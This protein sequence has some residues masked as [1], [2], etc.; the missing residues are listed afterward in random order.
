MRFCSLGLFG[1]IAWTAVGGVGY[2]ADPATK[3]SAKPNDP[4]KTI[5]AAVDG[6]PIYAIEIDRAAAAASGVI[7][8]TEARNPIV[9]AA[10]LNQLV[11][12]LL[13]DA[14]LEQA[15]FAPSKQDI[16]LEI[17]R[18]KAELARSKQTIEQF[19][20]RSGQTE[21]A[22]RAELARNL[23][24]QNYLKQALTDEALQAFFKAH[25]RDFDGTELR[26]SHILFRPTSAGDDST[27]AALAKDA[28][29][30]R[31][32]ILDGGLTF[33]GAAEKYSAGPSRHQG[34]DMGFIGRHGPMVEPFSRAAFAL[35]Q[36]EISPPVSTVFGVH[37]IQV[38]GIKPGEK[39]WTDVRDALRSAAGE[40]QFEQLAAKQRGKSKIEFTGACPYF[41][42][43]TTE[44]VVPGGK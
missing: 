41:K 18:L 13:V 44:L 35:E 6:K 20:T 10:L 12:Q 23:A 24:A 28:E 33:A 3:P 19:L 26:V 5:V 40:Q 37:L 27:T 39:K 42:P 4:A 30:V 31:R 29:Q 21:S 25:H 8:A 11:N 43:G 16:D 17:E 38:T 15:K 7:P 1:L 22:L 32:Q 36:G 9:R 2:P 34:G 14:Y